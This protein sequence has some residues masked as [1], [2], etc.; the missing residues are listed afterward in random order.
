MPDAQFP[1]P[2]AMLRGVRLAVPQPDSVSV[3]NTVKHLRELLG[4][5]AFN[6][7]MKSTAT[8]NNTVIGTDGSVT[9]G[10]A[11]P[12][13][14]GDGDEIMVDI[15]QLPDDSMEYSPDAAALRK[16]NDGYQMIAGRVVGDNADDSSGFDD[17]R[18]TELVAVPRQR[19]KYKG[20]FCACLCMIFWRLSQ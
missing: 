4:D 13:Y 5:A 20:K 1:F 12:F 18:E 14:D 3:D 11:S 19:S 17:V 10:R 15:S 7:H 16:R 8:N 9:A 2:F 6:E